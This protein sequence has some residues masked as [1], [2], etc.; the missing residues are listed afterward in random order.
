MTEVTAT[1]GTELA[2]IG[3]DEFGSAPVSS[4]DIMIPKLQLMQKM[5]RKLD[6]DDTL[7]EG[8]VIDSLSG[9]KVGGLKDPFEVLPFYMEKVWFTSVR[10]GEE[11]ELLSIEDVTVENENKRYNET[12][13]GKEYKNELHMRFYCIRPADAT[14]P[15]VL[16]FKGMSLKSGKL[17]A[18]QMYIKN[19]AAKLNPAGM[20]MNVSITKESN[21]KGTFC[22]MT[23][24]PA[25]RSTQ[26]E[27]QMALDWYRTVI[28]SKEVIRT[29]EV[30][31]KDVDAE[32]PDATVASGDGDF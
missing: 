28:A 7:R 21:D 18:T 30:R 19:R 27:Q 2:T 26:E 14:L 23:P 5:S 31:T 11:W 32:M 4:N 10:N 29:A 9:E 17:L 16:T 20:V 8:D 12:V 15:Y 22:V 24:S 6:A 25:R 13:N 3:L 1:T